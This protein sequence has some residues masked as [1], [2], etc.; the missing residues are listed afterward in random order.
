[1]KKPSYNVLSVDVAWVVRALPQ[2]A[3]RKA[4]ISVPAVPKEV[5]TDA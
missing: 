2:K 3:C 1:M 5:Y 4:D